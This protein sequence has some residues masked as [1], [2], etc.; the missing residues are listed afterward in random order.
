VSSLIS[1]L[2]LITLIGVSG[3]AAFWGPLL[4]LAR[5]RLPYIPCVDEV[6]GV[7]VLRTCVNV[8]GLFLALLTLIPYPGGAGPL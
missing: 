2:S 5:Q 8:V 1:F 3:I 7:R 6:S 4:I